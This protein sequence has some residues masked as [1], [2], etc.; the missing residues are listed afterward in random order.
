MK[1][2]MKMK[3]NFLGDK[4]SDWI[5]DISTGRHNW[6]GLIGQIDAGL[7]FFF[8]ETVK[9]FVMIDVV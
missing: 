9:I 7:N 6:A 3:L 2:K 4:I 5:L 1:M 8:F